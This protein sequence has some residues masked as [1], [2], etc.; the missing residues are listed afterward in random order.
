M[1]IPEKL[2][3]DVQYRER[4][5]KDLEYERDF[6]NPA[7]K[8]P[9]M[10]QLGGRDI[11]ELVRAA[12][13]FE[14]LCQGIDINAGCPQTRAITAGYGSA[15]LA[16]SQWSHLA[17][18]ISSLRS[19]VAVPVSVKIRLCNPV[20]ETVT[21]ARLLEQAGA[22]YITLHA[23]FPSANR[24]RHG[25]A[26]LEYVSALKGAVQIPVVSNGNVRAVKDISANLL[27]TGADG[28]M[29]AE[30]LLR[31]PHLFAEEQ[32]DPFELVD[33]YLENCQRFSGSATITTIQQHVHYFFE[34]DLLPKAWS[35]IIRK[36]IASCDSVQSLQN[37]I[38]ILKPSL[39][40]HKH[41]AT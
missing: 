23:R 11:E 38:K 40:V 29:V 35:S 14:P 13:L 8:P 6:F 27:S 17:Q 7:T 19:N 33:K 15:L 25:P 2:F 22:S 9:T 36:G 21:L 20:N 32:P 16:Q 37:K 41:Q 31:N 24:R 39:H 18:C 4:A 5:L 30:E 26:Q 1:Y 3:N 10:V 12:K 34:Q 28:I